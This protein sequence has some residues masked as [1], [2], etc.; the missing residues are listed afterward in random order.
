MKVVKIVYLVTHGE[1]TDGPNPGMTDEG[2]ARIRNLRPI[3]EDLLPNGRP[4]QVF[5]GTGARQI[6]VALC[7][8]FELKNI[9]F[10]DVWGG[11]ATLTK[12][13]GEKKVIL[14]D[15]TLVDYPDK[16][17]SSDDLAQAARDALKR[18]PH[19]SVI[20]S[21]RPTLIRVFKGLIEAE[22][23]HSGAIY[24]LSIYDNGEI[25][26]KLMV[27]GIILDDAKEDGHKV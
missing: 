23:C 6:E 19:G 9:F 24:S 13:G 7:L 16:F 17:L 12:I 20:T 27:I 22:E 5:C 4:S 21:G 18:L 8:G 14:A 10:S 2:K 25:T 1:K 3:L 26:P 15:G 11:P